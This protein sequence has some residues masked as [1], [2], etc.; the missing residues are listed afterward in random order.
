MNVQSKQIKDIIIA[1]AAAGNLSTDMTQI[2]ESIFDPVFNALAGPFI[3]GENY[4]IRTV[5]FHYTGKLIAVYPGEIVLDKA[6][7]IPDDGRFADALKTG[8]FNEVEPYL[9]D[10]PIIL[11]RGSIID[12][13]IFVHP[14]PTAQK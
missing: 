6:C 11:G 10:N 5:T 8:V 4:F 3:I 7:W 14:L 9:Q 1:Q 12:A 13:S 2:D